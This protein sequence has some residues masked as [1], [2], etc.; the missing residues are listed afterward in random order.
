MEIGGVHHHTA[1]L[2]LN[3]V[4]YVAGLLQ[5]LHPLQALFCGILCQEAARLDLLL[6]FVQMA[7]QGQCHAQAVLAGEHLLVM[8]SA[9]ALF[10]G[11][12]ADLRLHH[13]GTQDQIQ[14]RV[15]QLCKDPAEGAGAV[16]FVKSFV[17]LNGIDMFFQGDTS[18]FS[19][20]PFLL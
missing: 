6:Q 16:L 14:L 7:L 9:E 13:G 18:L 20:L 15:L 2:L 1:E 3:A 8:P 4:A 19:F 10:V 5:L 11:D 12:L 17:D